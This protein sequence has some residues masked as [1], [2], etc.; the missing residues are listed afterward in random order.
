M[1]DVCS[2]SLNATVES[3]DKKNHSTSNEDRRSSPSFYVNDASDNEMEGEVREDAKD[4][5]HNNYIPASS[6]AS[7]AQ[8]QI[9]YTD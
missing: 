5:M 4:T 2:D 1:I 3:K 9:A 7:G 6:F 8:A